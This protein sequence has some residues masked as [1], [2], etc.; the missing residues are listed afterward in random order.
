MKQLRT[1]VLALGAA[2][3]LAFG[4]CQKDTDGSTFT[5]TLERYADY[6][7][8][9]FLDGN[10]LK[11]DAG[12]QIIV[13][14]DHMYFGIYQAT[15]GGDTYTSFTYSPHASG[16]GM[17]IDV[18][19]PQASCYEG[20]NS[21]S[22][23]F[24]AI[25]PA[26]IVD[27]QQGGVVLS[28][29][30]Q[31]SDGNLHGFPMYAYSTNNNLSFKNAFGLIKLTIQ[32]A[33]TSI[34]S[35]S[36]TADRIINGLFTIDNNA[37]FTL[38]DGTVPPLVYANDGSGSHT[39]TLSLGTGSGIDV[40]T[41]H[42]FYICLPPTPSDNPY[43]NLTITLTNSE[44]AFCTLTTNSNVTIPVARS[45]YTAF[46]LID[47][48]PTDP[49]LVFTDISGLFSVG[50]NQY[51]QFS[52]GNLQYS[53]STNVYRFA[54]TQLDMIGVVNEQY[55]NGTLPTTDW[56]DLFPWGTDNPLVAITDDNMTTG[57]GTF[58]EWGNGNITNSGQYTWHTPSIDEWNYILFDR[59]NAL[60]KF[61]GA[62]VAGV[63]GL[64][65]LPDVWEQPSGCTFNPGFE[66]GV[67]Y[68]ANTYS[69]QQAQAMQAAGAVFLPASGLLI[70]N[71]DNCIY[72]HTYEYNP[73][74]DTNTST[75]PGWDGL[76]EA[77]GDM[78]SIIMWTIIHNSTIYWSS[79]PFNDVDSVLDV[80]ANTAFF[81]G[82]SPMSLPEDI[83]TSDD[84]NFDS[85]INAM[86]TQIPDARISTG[87]YVANFPF[88]S[89]M[90]GAVR[91]VR[92]VTPGASK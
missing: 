22:A 39:T 28:A 17:D 30:Q 19:D 65:I 67:F 8:K 88:I 63:Q 72:S 61:G 79:T 15:S 2:M 76:G 18:G 49:L 42:D 29:A 68:N 48:N 85:T 90:R 77:I 92:T 23:F 47:N 27:L 54:P 59:P 55:F 7:T 20:D 6:H 89:F 3:L 40:S 21:F 12:D 35:I 84:S 5:A 75:G 24:Q 37:E 86:T 81:M 16:T 14:N 74:W 31:S 57:F 78:I 83:F 25:Y 36:I 56:I 13:L 38:G 50:P 80:N 26:D 1:S 11:W 32:K 87:N 41:A 82:F 46:N 53:P 4:S 71:N 70:N 60:Q 52:P 69:A 62:T 44:G 10:R 91:L 58:Y 45:R 73:E 51:I 33:N 34:T 9:T 43:S 64:V 66:W